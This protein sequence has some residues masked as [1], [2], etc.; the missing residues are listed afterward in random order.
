MLPKAVLVFVLVY[1]TG[2]LARP[3]PDSL[4]YLPTLEYLRAVVRFSTYSLSEVT[5]DPVLKLEFDVSR[6]LSNVSQALSNTEEAAEK[7][8]KLLQAKDTFSDMQLLGETLQEMHQGLMDPDFH[9]PEYLEKENAFQEMELLNRTMSEHL[10]RVDFK[11]P[12]LDFNDLREINSFLTGATSQVMSSTVALLSISTVEKLQYYLKVLQ[13]PDS[14]EAIE[15]KNLQD[16]NQLV[17]SYHQLYGAAL[18]VA[19]QRYLREVA[20]GARQLQSMIR[21]LAFPR[22]SL[23]Q[24]AAQFSNRVDN[25]FQTAL[26]DLQ[27]MEQKA[28]DRFAEVLQ[29]IFYTSYG[30]V[31]SGMGMLRPYV[32]HIECVRELVPRAQTVAGVSLMSVSLCSNRATTTLYDATMVYHDKISQFQNQILAQLQMLEACAKLDGESC[33]T[34]YNETLENINANTDA[35]KNFAVD[36]EPYRVQLFSCF[37]SRYEIE[38][39]KVLDMA[40]NFDKCV[41]MTR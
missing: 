16:I 30:L 4:D 31:S 38:M 22:E 3:L 33:S 26:G 25:F 13:L 20:D 7:I 8:V 1:I 5:V 39:A 40:Y 14:M 17:R 6:A 27:T 35:V 9:F 12:T 11:K 36:F 41:K 19:S 32:R 10:S 28:D 2:C 23:E 34:V 29:H 18:N 15:L 21:S 24:A 37:T